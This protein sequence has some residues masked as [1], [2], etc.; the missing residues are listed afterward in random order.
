MFPNV[1][2]LVADEDGNQVFPSVDVVDFA[3]EV[4]FLQEKPM[5]QLGTTR[6]YVTGY[7]DL[8]RLM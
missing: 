3:S 1:S 8:V 2:V 4:S 5:G 6:I 7:T